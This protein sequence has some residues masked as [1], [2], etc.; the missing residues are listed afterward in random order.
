MIPRELKHKVRSVQTESALR[1]L[2]KTTQSRA[3][4]TLG[5]VFCLHGI[6]TWTTRGLSKETCLCTGAD[7]LSSYV[8]QRVVTGQLCCTSESCS[9][10]SSIWQETQRWPIRGRTLETIWARLALTLRTLTR[11]IGRHIWEKTTLLK[12]CST[13]IS[14]ASSS[15]ASL[16]PS[17]PP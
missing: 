13:P 7:W 2:L 1:L 4:F 5:H 9:V 3:L 8:N 11:P 17:I 6:D 16:T 10:I 15:D 12:W 14:P